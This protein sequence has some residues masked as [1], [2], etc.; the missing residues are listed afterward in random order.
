MR[1]L[2][3]IAYMLL[4]AS[5]CPGSSYDFPPEKRPSL[6]LKEA[7]SVGEKILSKLGLESRFYV[8]DVWITGH[9]K[10]AGSGA[11]HLRCCSQEG[12]EISMSIHFPADFCFVRPEPKEGNPQKMDTTQKGFTRDGQVSEEWIKMQQ[13]RLVPRPKVAPPSRKS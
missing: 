10:E 8:Y 11:W 7:C 9:E 5:M 3:V 1:S 13:N 2:I 12:D 4:S 6:S